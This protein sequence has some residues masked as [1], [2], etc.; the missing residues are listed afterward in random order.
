MNTA[1][2][3]HK[4]AVDID[5]YVVVAREV[6]GDRLTTLRPIG[7]RVATVLLNK[8]SGHVQTEVVINNFVGRDK[9]STA[10]ACID[11]LFDKLAIPLVEYFVARIEWEELAIGR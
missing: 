4:H 1:Q 9:L 8:T 7:S 3:T 10:L 5:P 6:I 11:L 2:I